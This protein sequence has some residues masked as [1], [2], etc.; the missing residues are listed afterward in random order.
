MASDGTE[1]AIDSPALESEGEEPAGYAPLGEE[2]DED[3]HTLIDAVAENDPIEDV[4][5]GG[6]QEDA[7]DENVELEEDDADGENAE[8]VSFGST[9]S[10]AAAEVAEPSSRAEEEEWTD[11]GGGFDD[12]DW[13]TPTENANGWVAD[14]EPAPEEPALPE[15]EVAMIRE[16]SERGPFD[17]PCWQGG[18]GRV[19]GK[20]GGRDEGRPGLLAGRRSAGTELSAAPSLAQWPRS[21]SR[22]HRGCGRCSRWPRSA[23][24]SRPPSISRPGSAPPS[25]R[26]STGRSRCRSARRTPT[27]SRPARSRARRRSRLTRRR[28]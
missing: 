20:V 10:E 25:R 17:A 15:E 3:E 26:S 14:F 8:W 6:S 4:E 7:D 28:R 12:T 23:R 21:T 9:E 2:S 11:F 5:T 22:L 16:A 19:V 27:C 13:A 1:T 24:C 18:R